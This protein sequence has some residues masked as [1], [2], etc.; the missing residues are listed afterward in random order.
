MDWSSFSKLTDRTSVDLLRQKLTFPGDPMMM[1]ESLGAH[2]IDLIARLVVYDGLLLDTAA[3]RPS[4]FNNPLSSDA[5]KIAQVQF[6]REIYEQ[7][8]KTTFQY[9]RTVKERKINGVDISELEDLF[10]GDFKRYVD[11]IS[12][13]VHGLGSLIADSNRSV[14]RALFYLELSRHA[15]LQLFLSYEKRNLL[16]DLERLLWQDAFSLVSDS[17][18]AAVVKSQTTDHDIRLETPPV[19][20]LVIRRAFKRKISLEESIIEVR[21]LEGAQQFRDLLAQIQRL[22]MLGDAAPKLKINK[23]LQPLLKAANTWSLAADPEVRWLWQAKI[24]K[25]PKIG[26]FLEALGIEIPAL[27]VKVPFHSYV[28]FVSEWYKVVQRETQ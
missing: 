10:Y 4:F 6:E 2:L 11:Q 25:L 20:D 23:L 22:L 15:G 24:N 1:R 8:A 12:R 26:A 18:N 16:N 17:V 21:N 5:V 19:V 28:Q 14:P 13:G 27:P 3:A 9:L 7:A